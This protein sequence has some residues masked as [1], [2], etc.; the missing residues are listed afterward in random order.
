MIDQAQRDGENWILS[1]QVLFEYYRLV[2]N[3]RVLELPLSAPEAAS[4]IEYFRNS[5]G[6]RY[7]AY[8]PR[9][10]GAVL[11]R[12]RAGDF[13]ARR[14]YD[15]VLAET[16]KHHGVRRLYTHNPKD[17]EDLGCFEVV[18]PIRV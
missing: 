15:L 3:P 5:L 14:V 10:L 7:C 16:L 4:F 12:A 2:R 1:D 11:T 6:V 13:L 17:F 18:D 9:H 8:E